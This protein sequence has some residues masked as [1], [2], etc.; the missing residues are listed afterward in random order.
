[1]HT[2]N[3]NAG[4]ACLEVDF[5]AGQSTVTRACA[6]NPLKLLT[7]RSRGASVWTYTST[8][9]GGFVA[10]DCVSLE[11]RLHPRTRCFLGSQASTKVYRNP[12][13]LPCRH[14]LRADLGPGSLLVLAPDPIQCFADSIYAQR[15]EFHL[16]AGAG[17]VLVDWLSAGRTARGERWAFRRFESRNEVFIGADR[18]MLD[19]LRLDPDDGPIDSPFRMGRFNCLATVVLAGLPLRDQANQILERVA[20]ESVARQSSLVIAASPLL[21]WTQSES[22]I[23][24]CNHETRYAPLPRPPV[25][26]APS[27]GERDGVRGS[28]LDAQQRGQADRK[29]RFTGDELR[30]QGVVLR[31]AGTSVEH[32]GS[33]IGQHLSFVRDLLE[34]DPWARKW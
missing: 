15:Q 5:V 27:D 2:T 6:A 18:L 19:S 14:S 3:T 17:L 1:V 10:G 24:P 28:G 34:D 12:N 25:T 8:F 20:S 31:L 7:P 22:P 26:L 9:G 16:E 4:R 29:V 33:L 23:A 32:V 21:G 13:A 30:P 11:V